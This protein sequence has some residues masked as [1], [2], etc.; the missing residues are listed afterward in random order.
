M[1]KTNLPFETIEN[2]QLRLDYL[3]TV[4]PRILG[5][6]LKGMEGN[7]LAETPEAHWP[8]PHGEYYLH[9][10]HRLWT[11]PEDLYTMCPEEGVEVLQKDSHITLHGSVEASGVQK[12][13]EI[14]LRENTVHLLHRVT[15]HGGQPVTLAPW[16]LTQARLGGMA[17]LPHA[18]GG[19]RLPDRNMVLWPY[20]Q[21]KDDRLDLHD[22]LILVHAYKT[23]KPFKIGT[24][25]SKD[26]I[27]YTLGNALFLKRFKQEG[28]GDFPDRGCNLEAY[29]GD[30][31]IELETLGALTLLSPG[32]SLTHEE[33][34]EL[35]AGEYPPTLEKAREIDAYY[36][37]TS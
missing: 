11:A 34:W 26:W 2:D 25:T 22:D 21:L 12:D 4:G 9:G 24:F 3:T 6:Y 1:Y 19:G 35:T 15:W 7:L 23:G 27:A 36:S 16:A 33:T 17:I 20:S 10:G 37:L 29:V 14:E 31:F 30:T 5:L 8:T 18:R 13:I 32:D 28:A